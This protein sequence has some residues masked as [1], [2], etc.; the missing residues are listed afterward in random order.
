MV[1]DNHNIGLVLHSQLSSLPHSDQNGL[2]NRKRRGSSPTDQDQIRNHIQGIH[3]HV[4]Q[5]HPNFYAYCYMFF[6]INNSVS[7][8]RRFC[9]HSTSPDEFNS[10]IRM[11]YCYH[12][13]SPID[14]STI[15]TCFNVVNLVLLYCYFHLKVTKQCAMMLINKKKSD[16]NVVCDA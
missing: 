11:R 9:F 2:P 1:H 15:V 13:R 4:F 16:F 5:G 7:R 12:S 14:L 8:M 6:M 3:L 10:V